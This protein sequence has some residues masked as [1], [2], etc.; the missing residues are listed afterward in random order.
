MKVEIYCLTNVHARTQLIECLIYNMCAH[1]DYKNLLTSLLGSTIYPIDPYQSPSLSRD[2][3][4]H[5]MTNA[6]LIPAADKL[7][8]WHPPRVPRINACWE[9]LKQARSS[10]SHVADRAGIAVPQ[11]PLFPRLNPEHARP[12]DMPGH[13]ERRRQADGYQIKNSWLFGAHS[14]NFKSGHATNG[15]GSPGG[16]CV[17]DSMLRDFF[18]KQ[19]GNDPGRDL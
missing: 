18:K 16:Q 10:H 11:C 3:V 5:H 7:R 1:I 17:R 6:D 8:H 15:T 12:G 4:L 19:L 2:T 14:G 9:R 13:R